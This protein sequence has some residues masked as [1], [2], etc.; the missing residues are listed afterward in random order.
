MQLFHAEADA[1]LKDKSTQYTWRD[2]FDQIL[3]KKLY[4]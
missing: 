4:A 2:R 1:D 3:T